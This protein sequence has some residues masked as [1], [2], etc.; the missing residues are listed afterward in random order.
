MRYDRVAP[1]R[2]RQPIRARGAA[3][4]LLVCLGIAHRPSCLKASLDPSCVGRVATGQPLLYLS[5]E[6]KP[7]PACSKGGHQNLTACSRRRRCRV[8]LYAC[9][10][11]LAMARTVNYALPALGS[12]LF[13]PVS[14][15]PFDG[16]AKQVR[17]AAGHLSQEDKKVDKEVPDE[18]RAQQN[19]YSF[20]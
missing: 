1:A 4:W 2:A 18:C 7:A 14:G 20:R 16:R 9:G 10:V 15:N 12:H 17:I 5:Y 6:T 8:F 19:V 13:L 3:T 11:T